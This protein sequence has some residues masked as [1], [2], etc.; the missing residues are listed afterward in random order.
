MVGRPTVNRGPKTPNLARRPGYR[1]K[2]ALHFDSHQTL[3]LIRR[4]SISVSSNKKTPD[5]H[6]KVVKTTM[7]L[8]DRVGWCG[9][10]GGHAQW[11]RGPEA[12]KRSHRR[13]DDD[14][15]PFHALRRQDGA[16]RTAAP[17]SLSSSSC[18]LERLRPRSDAS[19]RHA[20]GRNP[21]RKSVAWR[22][23]RRTS[24][25]V[26]SGRK[27]CYSASKHKKVVPGRPLHATA[28]ETARKGDA[29]APP[30]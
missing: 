18:S 10:R 25:R 22:G 16:E 7:P 15:I 13:V 28:T 19:K 3:A 30:R 23:W 4:V 29:C 12:T 2:H 20:L 1:R 24:Q 11:T 26:G 17:C 21:A 5:E 8:L 27:H 6:P 14:E 9:M